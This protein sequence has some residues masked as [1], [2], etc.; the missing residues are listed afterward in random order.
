MSRLG[1]EKSH[2]PKTDWITNFEPK[3]YFHVKVSCLVME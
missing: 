3:M 2:K 1:K